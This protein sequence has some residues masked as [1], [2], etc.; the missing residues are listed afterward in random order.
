V[1]PLV[2]SRSK[3]PWF[4]FCFLGCDRYQL[5]NIYRIPITSV[6]L[7]PCWLL[8]CP[9]FITIQRFTDSCHQPLLGSLLSSSFFSFPSS[10]W[11]LR[12][13]DRW[14]NYDIIYRIPV[15]LVIYYLI[16]HRGFFPELWYLL[17]FLVTQWFTDS[18]CQP[19]SVTWS[20]L[21]FVSLGFWGSFAWFS[22]CFP[23]PIN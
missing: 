7:L 23:K 18:W 1:Q 19:L 11:K 3:L 16:D 12:G 8:G 4:L 17:F 15:L 9:L 6:I 22:C 21:L 10:F 2:H 14:W 13:C 20:L 5:F